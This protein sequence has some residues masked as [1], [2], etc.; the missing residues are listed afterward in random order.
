MHEINKYRLHSHQCISLSD[1]RSALLFL[2]SPGQAG[3]NYPF[4][5][6]TPIHD[7]LSLFPLFPGLFYQRQRKHEIVKKHPDVKKQER[8]KQILFV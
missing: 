6:K 5:S 2:L 4:N 8:R 7:S 3:K 1:H